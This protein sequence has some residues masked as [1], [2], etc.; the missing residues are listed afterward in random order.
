MRSGSAE[1]SELWQ[2]WLHSWTRFAAPLSGDVT[3]A[4]ETSLIRITAPASGDPALERQIVEHVA[5]Y[6]RQL[7]RVLDGLAVLA[8]HADRSALDEAERTALEGVLGLVTEIEAAKVRE[9]ARQ[10]DR[11]VSEIRTLRR[12]AEGNASALARIR[13]ALND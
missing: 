5:S 2:Q 10:T 13:A 4:I 11:I 1:L 3:Q 6:G 9:A 12:D 8:R 7:G